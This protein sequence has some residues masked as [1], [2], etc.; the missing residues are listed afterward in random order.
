MK[1]SLLFIFCCLFVITL[2]GCGKKELENE[3]SKEIYV[4]FEA[5]GDDMLKV[6]ES[7]N[8]GEIVNET[9]S[10]G[11]MS[12]EGILIRDILTEW[13]VVSIEACVD[14]ELEGWMAYKM[15]STTDENDFVTYTAEKISDN[16][17]TTE[18]I[19]DSKTPSYDVTYYAKC[20]SKPIE[21]YDIQ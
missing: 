4:S 8:D 1:K 5:Y 21:Y 10:M 20:K 15:T 6:T 2:T 17:Y 14:D 11:W 13:E 7:T 3:S 12:E 19:L 16:L 9:G 18:E